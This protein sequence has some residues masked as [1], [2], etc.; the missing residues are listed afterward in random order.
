MVT[1][2]RYHTWIDLKLLNLLSYHSLTLSMLVPICNPSLKKRILDHVVQKFLR[3]YIP[4]ARWGISLL[5][6]LEHFLAHVLQ[7]STKPVMYGQVLFMLCH[8]NTSACLTHTGPLF[9]ELGMFIAVTIK[10][11]RE[12]GLILTHLFFFFLVYD[13]NSPLFVV[14]DHNEA[15]SQSRSSSFS[16]QP[17]SS[18][19]H[20]RVIG[21]LDMPFGV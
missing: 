16:Q 5:C 14:C 11:A 3:V 21:T 4:V 8:A 19:Y 12:K 10:K 1:V 20:T 13:Q 6:F 9:S 18:G 17:C 2:K 7:P 15:E